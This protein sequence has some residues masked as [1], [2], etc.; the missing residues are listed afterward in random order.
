MSK[1]AIVG[2]GG[3][4]PLNF[5]VVGGTTQP[6]NPSEN[7]IWV[8]TSA[9]VTGWVFSVAQPTGS[10]GLVWF[11]TGTS[12]NTPF[13]ALKKNNITVY[14][15]TCKQYVNGTWAS[16]TTEVYQSGAWVDWRVYFYNKGVECTDLTGGWIG[17][18]SS[19]Y[20]SKG[21]FTKGTDK[22][23]ISRTGRQAVTAQTSIAYDLTNLTTIYANI[24]KVTTNCAFAV[25]KNS[26]ADALNAASAK[27]TVTSA[28]LAQIDVSNITGLHYIA[29][30]TWG[31][32]VAG[33]IQFNEVYAI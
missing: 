13:N 15:N 28:G 14:P 24:L 33:E 2:V 22:I 16:K 23:T 1:G 27:A 18:N 11:Q 6:A 21:T 31:E 26:P 3:G 9:A 32:S 4:A 8:N 10:E 7:T 19:T 29:I 5:K 20:Y 12:S 30:G 17:T 25:C